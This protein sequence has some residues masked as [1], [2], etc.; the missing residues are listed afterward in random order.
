MMTESKPRWMDLLLSEEMLARLNQIASTR[1]QEYQTAEPFPHIVMDDFLP[2]EVAEAAL[3][4]FPSPQERYWDK[5]ESAH[6]L[7]LAFDQ[8]ERMADSHRDILYFFN[9]APMLQFLERLTGIDGLIADPYFTGGGLHQIPRGGKLE[10]H[11]DFNRY[12]RWELDRRLNILLYMNKEWRED[13]GGHLQFWDRTMTTPE[14]RILP[15]FNRCAIFSTS[16]FSYHGHPEP[17]NCPEGWTRK[18]M[19]AY[20]YSN[21]RPDPE[22]SDAHNTLFQRRPGV[23]YPQLMP[24]KNPLKRAVRM[25]VPPIIMDT[26]Y[27]LRTRG[28]GNGNGS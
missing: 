17:L 20:Y 2:V 27:N 21:G 10:V 7:K 23:L 6:E 13:Y 9:S 14:Q 4:D 22:R 19:A 12:Q 8:A 5:M 16:E 24:E 18:S 3:R 25:L 28:N 26:Y 15:I 11:V 1:A